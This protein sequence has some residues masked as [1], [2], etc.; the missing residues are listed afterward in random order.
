MLNKN[1]SCANCKYADYYFAWW[2]R[3]FD[4][5]CQIHKD[6]CSVDRVCEDFEYCC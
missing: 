2:H 6:I 3:Y 5:F 1:R 4:P